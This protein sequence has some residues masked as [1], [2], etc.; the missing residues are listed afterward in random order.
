MSSNILMKCKHL[1]VLIT[2]IWFWYCKPENWVG[3]IQGREQSSGKKGSKTKRGMSSSKVDVPRPFCQRGSGG[4]TCGLSEQNSDWWVTWRPGKT[5]R[6]TEFAMQQLH[7]KSWEVGNAL[8]PSNSVHDPHGV[9]DHP[10][11]WMQTAVWTHSE[12]PLPI[13]PIINIILSYSVLQ[14]G[15]WKFLWWKV[16]C[17]ALRSGPNTNSQLSWHKKHWGH[18][19]SY[20]LGIFLCGWQ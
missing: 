12:L 9:S 18:P 1:A 13:Y 10:F 8:V 16:G 15:C 6:K 14:R 4:V 17:C 11:S 3:L 20:S 7:D 5:R 2:N 19:H